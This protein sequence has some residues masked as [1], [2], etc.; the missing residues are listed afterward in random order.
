[1]GE[2]QCSPPTGTCTYYHLTA[3][4]VL[5]EPDAAVAASFEVVAQ[6]EIGLAEGQRLGCRVDLGIGLGLEPDRDR[7]YLP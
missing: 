4:V 2:T 5:W 3:T 6:Q 1:M 7:H